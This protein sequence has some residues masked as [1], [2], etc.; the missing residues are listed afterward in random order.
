MPIDAI[1]FGGRRATNV[2]LVNGA[3]DW[4]HGVFI[5]ATVSSETTAAAE[6]AMGQLRRDPFAMLPFCGYNMADYWGHWLKIGKS[7]SPDKLPRIFQVNWFRKD[8]AGKFLWPG[9]GENSRVLAWIIDQVNGV[10]NGIDTPVGIAPA[11]GSLF[12]DGLDVTDEQVAELFAID[13]DR[14][15]AECDLTEE[16]FAKFGEA[17]PPE[18]YELLGQLRARL[19]AAKA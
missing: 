6:G 10:D 9:F 15:L 7:T 8:A 18:L 14:W 3:R 11:P 12:L 5:G 19:E 4:T 13:P 16:Y 17:T 1:L 2:P